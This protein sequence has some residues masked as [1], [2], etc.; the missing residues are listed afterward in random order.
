[1]M[2]TAEKTCGGKNKPT[3]VNFIS[4]KGFVLVSE[5]SQYLSVEK[6]YIMEKNP[7]IKRL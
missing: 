1:M 6:R 2:Q 7:Q 4:D 3:R 5:L